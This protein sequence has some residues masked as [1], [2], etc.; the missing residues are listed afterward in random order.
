MFHFSLRIW[1]LVKCSDGP[2]YKLWNDFLIKLEAY[3]VDM[4]S[5]TDQSIMYL[6]GH[7]T[8]TTTTTNA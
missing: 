1:C 6:S 3:V 7:P 4:L 2:S 5:L 8:N